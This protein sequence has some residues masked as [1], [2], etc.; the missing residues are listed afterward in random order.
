MKGLIVAAGYGTRFLPATKTVPKEMLPLIDTPSIAFVIDEFISAGIHEI[1][2]I[3][4]RRKK[5]LEDYFD[6]DIELESLFMREGDQEK[7]RKIIPPRVSVTFIRQQEMLGTGHALLQAKGIL[8][9]D[10][11]ICAYPDD[12]HFGSPSL[13]EQ[14]AET[15]RQTGCT[16]LATLHDPPQLDR[17]GILDL[18]EDGVHVKNIVEKPPKGKEP[19][20][21]ASIGRYLYTPDIFPL[22]EEGWERHDPSRG[23]YF[24]VYALKR[25]MD[26]RRVV[27]RRI[28]GERLDIGSPQ[29]YLRAL[30]RYA[31]GRPDLAE[32]MQDELSLY[33]SARDA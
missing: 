8:G 20:R 15:Y 1:V 30:I 10:P 5:S 29:G 4:S 24:H 12:I 22:L 23:E 27:H 13:S 32:V 18:E 26:Q 14:L 16:V 25:L 3:T 6:R 17:Y 9:N 11:F 21:E 19:S 28:S 31:L 7:L 33:S 2:I